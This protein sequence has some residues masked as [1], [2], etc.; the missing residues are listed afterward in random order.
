MTGIALLTFDLDNTLW[1]VES[2][3]LRAE[4]G[5]HAWLDQHYPAWQDLGRDGLRRLRAQIMQCRPEI[6]HDLTALRLEVL[7]QGLCAAGY[8]L[9]Q[10]TEGATGAFDVFF[11]ARNEVTLYDG[12]LPVLAELSA[13]YPLYAL[14]NGNADIVRAGL[15]AYFSGQLSAASVGY[16]K[17]HPRI[18]EQALAQAGVTAGQAV[19]I[20]DHPEQDIAAA[21]AVG[22]RAIWC[23]HAQ[24]E[25]PLARRPEGEFRHFSELPA[26]LARLT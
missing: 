10:A 21:Q 6:I 14:S 19:H 18:Y 5:M 9:T 16:A 12:V 3:I 8:N 4:A 26:L 1:D 15:G 11:Q 17:P 7:R 2:V 22:M 13:R 24:L 25:W 20:G 23:N